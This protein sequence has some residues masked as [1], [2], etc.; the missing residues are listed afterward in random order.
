MWMRCRLKFLFIL[1]LSL[2]SD[3]KMLRSIKN[4]NNTWFEVKTTQC[5]LFV[6]KNLIFYLYFTHYIIKPQK[7]GY[8]V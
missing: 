4:E 6:F 8:Y 7:E 2:L 5:S 1:A 3:L